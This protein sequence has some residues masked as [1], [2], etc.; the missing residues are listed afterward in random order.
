[1]VFIDDTQK[2]L[3]E[4]LK[5]GDVIIIDNKIKELYASELSPVLEQYRH[6]A[7]D[8]LES[9]KSYQ[10]VMPIIQDLIE[11]GFR[12]NHRLIAIGGGITQDTTAFIASIMYRGVKWLFFPTSLLAQGDSCIGSKT[13]INFDKYKN[14]IGGF[15][16]PNQIFINLA[17]L[18][19]LTEAEI[20]S[21]MGEMLHYFIVSGKEDFDFYRANYEQALTDKKVLAS[22]I[23]RSLEI[24]KS[25]I[26]RDEF[27]QHDRIVFNYG[28]TFGHAIESLTNYRIPHGIAVSYGMDM[29]NF[30][31]VKLGYIPDEVRQEIRK[32]TEKIWAGTHIT[33]I[34]IDKYTTALSKDKKNV[35]KL[36][37]LILNKGYGKIFKDLRPM[38]DEFVGWMKEYFSTQL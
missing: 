29:S 32:V 24:K 27:D 38:D 26:E 33:D 1:V 12:K 37:G 21:G 8:A 11:N 36:L 28:H 17:F 7:I 3:L 20:K 10:G 6:I 15:Y 9:V 5:A 16:P 31:S 30:V 18:D 34:S 23:N 2:A 4:Q 13:S 19:T 25:Y 22:I 14:Q 35:D